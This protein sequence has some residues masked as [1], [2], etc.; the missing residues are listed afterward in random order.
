L[1]QEDLPALEHDAAHG[2]CVSSAPFVTPSRS[3]WSNVCPESPGSS[4]GRSG[5]RG[6]PSIEGVTCDRRSHSRICGP[7]SG[8]AGRSATRFPRMIS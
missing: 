2:S 7:S 8:V 5:N 4:T 6:G 1:H 3:W